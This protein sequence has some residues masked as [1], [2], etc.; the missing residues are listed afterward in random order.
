MG[1]QLCYENIDLFFPTFFPTDPVNM[2]F[3]ITAADELG[4]YKLFEGG[5]G[6][7][8]ESQTL[9]KFRHQM[10]GQHHI[11]HPKTGRN[12]FGKAVQIDHVVVGTVAEQG[13]PGLAGQRKL[14]LKIVLG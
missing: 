1:C 13:F 12:G 14:R 9:L 6:A 2:T 3:K 4:Q 8:I 10:P 11:A 5:N 7:G